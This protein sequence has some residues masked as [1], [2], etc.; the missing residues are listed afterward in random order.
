[1][2]GTGFRASDDTG[3][4][5]IIVQS[6]FLHRVFG[7]APERAAADV[8]EFDTPN[9][10]DGSSRDEIVAEYVDAIGRLSAAN[11]AN[12]LWW[13]TDLASKNR[14][15]SPLSPLINDMLRLRAADA[16]AQASGRQL[17]LR[18]PPWPIAA[19]A[20]AVA[21]AR[22][23]RV[24]IRAWPFARLFWRLRGQWSA[25]L[26]LLKGAAMS[27]LQV[28]LAR[29]HYGSPPETGL[30]VY[31]I[32]S[33]IYDKDF[34]DTGRHRDAFFGRFPDAAAARLAPLGAGVL[35]VVLGFENKAACYERLRTLADQCVV[36]MESYLSP[37]DVLAA[38][39][40]CTASVLRHRVKVP[41]SL[42]LFGMN[43]A[44]L[45]RETVAAGG[46]QLA[47]F[48][49][50][51]GRAAENIAA[52]HRLV[53]CAMTYEL[54]PWERPFIAGLRR[55]QPGTPVFGFQH[56]IVTQAGTG[57]FLSRH[58][59]PIAPLPDAILTTGRV[60]ARIIA[61]YGAFPEDRI[62]PL[63]ALRYEI[64]DRLSPSPRP[65]GDGAPRVLV[66]LEGVHP[67]VVLLEYAL[68]QA[69]AHPHIR[70]RVRAHP[71]F[72]LDKMCEMLPPEQQVFPENVEA[73]SAPSVHQDVAE[74]D[75]VLYW[76]TTV[77]LEAVMIGRPIIHF[78]RGDALSYDPLFEIDAFHWTV[79]RGDAIAD[80]MAEIEALSDDDYGSQQRRAAEYIK[81]YF[82]PVSENVISR[83][84]PEPPTTNYSTI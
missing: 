77:A 31:L 72:P 53:G 58:E 34:D 9:G 69:A 55:V 49:F 15:I 13:A 45:V 19:L 27:M 22:G 50:L 32:K 47:F 40:A 11:A 84:V 78:D 80:V 29:R 56:S 17:I 67:A 25:A 63:G 21:R 59:A 44:P 6:D 75:A 2:P 52:R 23:E 57:I 76:G 62:W 60:P 7:P 41:E 28:R 24:R 10:L 38:F 64:L 18:R 20:A 39:A 65:S 79:R 51:H 30:P 1:M 42:P 37:M 73:S 61:T 14:F 35:T 81:E 43:T 74:S 8:C 36:P 46:W 16:A 82:I 54:N 4:P 70:F 12:P 5:M 71:V 68:A 26:A 66:A 48:Q 33:F 3:R 83:A